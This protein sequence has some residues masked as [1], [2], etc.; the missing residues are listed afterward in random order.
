MKTYDKLRTSRNDG[1][2]EIRRKLT[3]ESLAASGGG[4]RHVAVDWWETGDRRR[5]LEFGFIL[6]F[7][8]VL[9]KG[10]G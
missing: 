7:F 2:R 9:G 8:F 6:L 3:V 5:V 1:E 4:K 10:E